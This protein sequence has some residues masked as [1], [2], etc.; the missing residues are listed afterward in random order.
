MYLKI[1][2]FVNIMIFNIVLP[3]LIC[4]CLYNFVFETL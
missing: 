4:W 3:R 2:L 1:L